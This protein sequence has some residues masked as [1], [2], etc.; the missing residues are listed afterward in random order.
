MLFH[1]D[2]SAFWMALELRDSP[3]ETIPEQATATQ[4]PYY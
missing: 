4:E 1:D 3:E 2:V